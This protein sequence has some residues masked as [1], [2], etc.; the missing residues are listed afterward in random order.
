MILRKNDIYK[1]KLPYGKN[2]KHK[3]YLDLYSNPQPTVNIVEHVRRSEIKCS[4]LKNINVN[5]KDF[6]NILDLYVNNID[7]FYHFNSAYYPGYSVIDIVAKNKNDEYIY[8][9]IS[10]NV[11]ENSPPNNNILI[12]HDKNW[13]IFWNTFIP[14]GIKT[15]I[16]TQNEYLLDESDKYEPKFNPVNYILPVSIAILSLTLFVFYNRK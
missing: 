14:G 1:Y 12:K 8:I 5:R 16:L 9:E 15:K 7:Y 13:Q 2:I 3:I 4:Y 6:K 10:R 11:Y